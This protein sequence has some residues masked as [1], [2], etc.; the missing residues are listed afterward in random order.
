MGGKALDVGS[1]S[2]RSHHVPDSLGCDSIA[3]DLSQ[4]TYSPE[5]RA[6]VDA[7]RRGPLIDGAFRPH[8]NWNGADVLSFAHQVSD[9]PALLANL[10][11]F[12][13]QSNQFGPPQAA[14]MCSSA[15]SHHISDISSMYSRKFRQLFL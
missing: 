15:S 8:R 4:P 6:T 5:D 3:P 14:A 11:I 7:G 12:R 2:G 13:S 10:E 9:Y 1:L